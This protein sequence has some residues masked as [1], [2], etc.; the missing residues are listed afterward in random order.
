M[1]QSQ[2]EWTFDIPEF[3]N[4]GVACTSKYQGT[5][6]EDRIAMII[7]DSE[8]GTDQITYG[9]LDKRT[10]QF[11][12]FVQSIGLEVRDR[13]LLFLKNSLAYPTGFFGCIKAG[14]IAVPTSTLL[15]GSEVKY[16]AMDSQAKL[17]VL[18]KHSY[19]DLLPYVE[20][21]DNLQHIVVADVDSLD[22]L[23]LSDSVKTYALN[24]ILKNTDATPNNYASKNGEP[25]YLVYTS[26]T[27]GF[28][29]GVLHSHRSLLGRGP[30]SK[31]WFNLQD[32][33]RIMHSGK[34]NWTYVLG[35]ALMD[36]LYYGHT[37]VAY[38]GK[39]DAGT[40]V[41]LIK[42]HQCTI[43]IGVPTIYRQIIQKTEYTIE[44][45]PSL[46]HCMSAGEHLSSEMVQA[47]QERF[48]QNI[49]EAI[50]MSE[51]SYYISHSIHNPI[52]PG[53]AGF[54]QPGHNVKLLNPQTLEEVEG[55]EEGM[56]CID[57]NDPGLFLEYWQ[58][59]DQT[60][61]A[62]HNG[63]FFTGDYAKR[64]KDGY[65]W[66]LGRKDDII[67]TFGYRVSPHEIERVMKTHEL[68]GDCVAFGFDVSAGKTIVAVAIIGKQDITP[69]QEEEI[70]R[71]GQTH[72]ARYKSPKQVY[73]LNDF[74]RTKN[75]KVLRGQLVKEIHEKAAEDAEKGSFKPEIYRAR[76]SM[77]YVLA[78][79]K[80]HIEKSRS[81]LT[82]AVIFDMNNVLPEHKQEARDLLEQEFTNDPSF[83]Y[84]ERVLRVNY[85]G[86]EEIVR[87]IELAK[88]IDI[89]AILFPAIE[90]PE[91][92]LEA[93]KLLNSVGK[94]LEFMINIGTPLGVLNV[95]QICA[96]SEN[97]K[98][99]V[100][101]SNKLSSRMQ[102]NIQKDNAPLLHFLSQVALAAR[103]YNKIVIDGPHYNVED[104]F[105]CE[106]STRQSFQL[107][108][109]GK[110]LI[111]PVQVEYINDMFTPKKVEVE[112]SMRMIEAYEKAQR[113]GQDFISFEGE[114]VD[115]YQV[116]W[117]QRM[118]TLY[119]KYKELGQ[120]SFV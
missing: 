108:F 45:C 55:E 112:R 22:E 67:N 19:R 82:D 102:I 110:A 93:E 76:R 14:I 59:E 68:I 96:A 40:W 117:A 74:P 42:R 27:T 78:S 92:L 66:F 85:L 61:E 10:N 62:R 52:R 21:L 115:K 38:E 26:G 77:L 8:L 116:N 86:T 43:F 109:D 97:L 7:E 95:Q 12:N 69:E 2:T 51:C 53:S 54:V 119:D 87:D 80:R 31:Y 9:K 114:V 4:I 41:E 104:E 99:L 17:L 47:W 25:A 18:N 36:P 49:Y 34:F 15:S 88:K 89:E 75:G 60:R 100:V 101:S 103:A 57:E 5:D 1:S 107:G 50:G 3:F 65:I 56:I 70:L 46:R 48:Q 94:P 73:V 79:N 81:L 11:S 13:A 105:S 28:P 83:G 118:I 71:Y 35:S 63:Y 106:A 120:D 58:L 37:V 20:Q 23:E 29:K 113:K 6:D 44:D 64:D 16:L 84:S 72:L 111:H 90:T 32:E 30:A 39:N 24:D 91:Q 98:V 33:E